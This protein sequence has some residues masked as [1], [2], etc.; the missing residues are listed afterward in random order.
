VSEPSPALVAYARQFGIGPAE[1]PARLAERFG[2]RFARETLRAGESTWGPGPLTPRERSLLIVA[3]LVTQGAVDDRL[4]GHVR[5]A[6]AHGLDAEE[7][8]AAVTLLAGYAGFPRAS[9][10]MEVVR[11][12]LGL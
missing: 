6:L 11:S 10:A 2:E 8:E 3:S 5:L 4:R 9:V 12:E 7:L 1:V